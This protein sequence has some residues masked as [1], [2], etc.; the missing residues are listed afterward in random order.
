MKY[1][2]LQLLVALLTFAW[3]W[4]GFP[5]AARA[6][7]SPPAL[8]ASDFS[9]VEYYDPPNERQA[10]FRI[11]GA[12]AQPQPGGLVLLQQLTI[13]CFRVTGETEIVVESPRCVWNTAKGQ[14]SSPGRLELRSGDRRVSVA[15]E[16]FRW[17]QDQGS[18]TM[19]NQIR[20]ILR[21]AET[22]AAAGPPLVI[23]S[24][25]FNF[26]A[27]NRSAT[28]HEDVRGDDPE[29]EFT[30][31]QLSIHGAPAGTPKA[32]Q[33]FEIIEAGPSF[34]IVGKADGRRATADQGIYVHSAERIELIGNVRWQQDRQSGRA[35]RAI[36][37]RLEK[38]VVASGQVAM[39]LPR[40]SLGAGGRL[41]ARTNAPAAAGDTPLIDLFAD[42]FHSRS[43]LTVL[44][45]AV[46]VLDGTNQL[47]CDKLTVISATEA[48]PEETATAEGSVVLNQGNGTLR[49]AR[50]V[51]TKSAATVVFTGE[52]KWN[53]NQMEGQAE[54]VTIHTETEAI[55]AENQVVVKVPLPGQRSSFLTMFPATANTSNPVQAVEVFAR[56]FT[57]QDRRIVFLGDV[58]AHQLPASGAEPRLRSDELEVQFAPAANQAETLQARKNVVYEQGLPGSTNG[59]TI[60]RRLTTRALTARSDTNTGNLVDMV[61]EGDVDITQ[62]GSVARGGRATYTAATDFLEL[63]EQPSLETPQFIITDARSLFWDK[64]RGRYRGTGLYK[65]RFRPE[66][67]KQT[68]EK[69][70][71]P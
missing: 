18:L 40:E 22:N 32:G 21:R 3:V 51:Y 39:K 54:R 44:D 10:R 25:W 53:Q 9:T 60:Y 46:R 63:T 27:T 7:N 12:A 33:S 19:S 70:K 65:I 55:H 59:P 62:P 11:R 28:F 6:Q 4:A 66:A 69:F 35:D 23:T 50:A 29:M 45:G 64:A 61:A 42:Q 15:G 8:S 38:D 5:P 26:E 48:A 17:Q 13:E 41:L 31:G 16:G 30:C 56:E 52:P 68:A 58:R 49:A 57:G 67:L 2:P 14:A 34:V 24:R 47:A 36:V 43:N 37:H 71:K 20:A 1:P